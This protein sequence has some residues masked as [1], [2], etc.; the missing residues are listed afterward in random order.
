MNR[1]PLADEAVGSRPAPPAAHAAGKPLPP[2]IQPLVDRLLAFLAQ[3]GC[4]DAEFDDLAAAI[5]A[6]QYAHDEPYR[7]FC[8]RR[9]VNPRRVSGWRQ[10]PPVPVSA[11]KD[12]T[13]TCVPPWTASA[14]S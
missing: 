10:V 4:S 14:Y 1:Y 2:T 5:F 12:A 7:R 13:L 9:G 6:C 8:Q 11:F 3:D